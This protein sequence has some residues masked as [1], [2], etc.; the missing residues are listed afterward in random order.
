M[1]DS[2]G[3]QF[4]Y[5]VFVNLCNTDDGHYYKVFCGNASAAQNLEGLVRMEL[6]N[7]YGKQ[8]FGRTTDDGRHEEYEKEIWPERFNA[9]YDIEIHA[10]TL[11]ALER[12]HEYGIYGDWGAYFPKKDVKVI[13]EFLA[14]IQKEMDEHEFSIDFEDYRRALAKQYFKRRGH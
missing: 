13:D 7:A 14:Q 4:V 9:K 11:N 6:Q 2:Y 5:A 12:P 1:K 10:S 8:R 3:R